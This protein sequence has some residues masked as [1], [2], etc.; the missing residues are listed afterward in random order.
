[1][2][3]FVGYGQRPALSA[4][5]IRRHPDYVENA[6]RCRNGVP[7]KVRKAQREASNGSDTAPRRRGNESTRMRSKLEEAD[8]RTHRRGSRDLELRFDLEVAFG[9]GRRT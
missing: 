9:L 8:L 3:H 5:T 7:E 2:A 6:E 1:M 4:A